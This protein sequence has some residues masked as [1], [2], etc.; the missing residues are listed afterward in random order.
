LLDPRFVL[1]LLALVASSCGGAERPADAAPGWIDRYCAD[2]ASVAKLKC[3]G[4]TPATFEPTPNLSILRP[5]P[6]GYVLEADDRGVHWTIAGSRGPKPVLA[7]YGESRVVGTTQVGGRPAQWR[8]ASS[9]SGVFADHLVLA[10]SDGGAAYAV[11]AH[12]ASSTIRERI[13]AVARRM[14]R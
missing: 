1:L 4:T 12:D 11:S 7:A 9:T 5:S 10:W 2:V 14:R 8:K 6:G 13:A 3:P